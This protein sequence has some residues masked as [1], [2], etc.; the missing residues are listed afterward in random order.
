MPQTLNNQARSLQ[1]GTALIE[2]LAGFSL[3]LLV[4]TGIC[5]SQAA[6]V[7]LYRKMKQSQDYHT[8]I[9]T[10]HRQLR[11]WVNSLPAGDFALP[12]PILHT[13]ASVS[14]V[15]I[16][17]ALRFSP[18][19]GKRCRIM[20]PELENAFFGPALPEQTYYSTSQP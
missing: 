6:F 9:H 16:N 3:L 7:D 1:R 11:P 13:P 10:I 17:S 19:Y 20:L 5:R 14:C 4:L 12:A 2:L 8:A 15:S 18:V